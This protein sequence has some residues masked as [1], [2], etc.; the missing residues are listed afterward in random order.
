[1]DPCVDMAFNLSKNQIVTLDTPI[2]L[3]PASCSAL[4]IQSY[5]ASKLL[6]NLDRPKPGLKIRDLIPSSLRPC[7]GTFS[8]SVFTGAAAASSIV[9]VVLPVSADWSYIETFEDDF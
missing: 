7:G 6:L 3:L 5:R 1:V 8:L 9:P 2:L 4:A